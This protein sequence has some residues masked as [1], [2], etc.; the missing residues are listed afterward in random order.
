M[1]VDDSQWFVLGFTSDDVVGAGQDS[2]LAFECLKAW[3]AADRPAGFE[4]WQA[5][6]DGDYIVHWFVNQASAC[7]LD[8]QGIAWRQFVTGGCA[9]PPARADLIVTSAG[10]KQR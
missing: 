5:S 8:A 4:I 1:R 6:G 7:F 3:E 2:R 9:A 10:D